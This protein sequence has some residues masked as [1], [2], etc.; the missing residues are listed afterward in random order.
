MAMAGSLCG[1]AATGDLNVIHEM[2]ARGRSVDER[3]TH[4]NTPLHHACLAGNLPVVEG[5]L[6]YGADVNAVNLHGKSCLQFAAHSGDTRIIYRLLDDGANVKHQS[7]DGKT[8]LHSAVSNDFPDASRILIEAGCGVD[9]A[10]NEG[11]TPLHKA[12]QKD[13]VECIEL[14]RSYGANQWTRNKS[15]QSSVDIARD[16]KLTEALQALMSVP[17]PKSHWTGVPDDD[18]RRSPTRLK[19]AAS[20]VTQVQQNRSSSS[21]A[22]NKNAVLTGDKSTEENTTNQL[23]EM[24]TKSYE[25]GSSHLN[26][27]TSTANDEQ[28]PK[29]IENEPV[30][31]AQQPDQPLLSNAEPTNVASS[32]NTTAPSSSN[33]TAAAPAEPVIPP[34]LVSYVSESSLPDDAA[35]D[36]APATSSQSS[37]SGKVVETPLT[38]QELLS[39]PG[40]RHVSIFPFL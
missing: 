27:T 18:V 40:V 31:A 33:T 3:D 37:S 25:I 7:K 12:T 22:A 5:L 29:K 36:T 24:L 34:S 26:T 8:A 9:L 14:L 10:E 13:F 30:Q 38:L 21:A 19:S 16:N 2:M 17:L 1:A 32:S 11:N 20:A 15:G 28:K 39:V 4:Q 6:S 35:L 23:R